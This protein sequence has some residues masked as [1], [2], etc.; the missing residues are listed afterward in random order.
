MTPTTALLNRE[1]VI[2]RYLAHTMYG[3]GMHLAEIAEQLRVTERTVCRYLRQERPEAPSRQQTTPLLESFH[4]QGSCRTHLEL[5]WFTDD[6]YE[7]RELKAI[8]AQCPVLAN[9]RAYALSGLTDE[10][11][12]WG[13]MTRDERKAAQREGKVA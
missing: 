11:G 13:A 8:C 4:Q 3:R 5:D 6:K 12:V 9:C 7:I 10:W 1:R 2:A